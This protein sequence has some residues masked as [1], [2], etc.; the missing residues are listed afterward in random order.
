VPFNIELIADGATYGEH[1][2][3]T[4]G[5]PI[6]ELPASADI[7]PNWYFIGWSQDGVSMLQASDVLASADPF[8]AHFVRIYTVRF[9]A[10]GGTITGEDTPTTNRSATYTHNFAVPQATRSGHTFVY[11]YAQ[12]GSDT[13]IVTNATEVWALDS[14]PRNPAVMGVS[15]MTLADDAE[16]DSYLTVRAQ[17]E[18]APNNWWRTLLGILLGT[19]LAVVLMFLGG[20]L[21]G[22]AFCWYLENCA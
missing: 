12:V 5:E 16:D 3:V 2:Y 21:A 17:W 20:R 19:V 9:D 8:V 1:G 15:A 7:G 11:W 14:N 10:M 18:A 22:T 13:V 6:G 4:I